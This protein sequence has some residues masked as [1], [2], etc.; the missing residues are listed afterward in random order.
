MQGPGRPGS[1]RAM[2][3]RRIVW[4]VL[5]WALGVGGLAVA[6]FLLKCLMHAAGMR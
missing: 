1:P 3:V 5:F 6:A 4:F 2:A